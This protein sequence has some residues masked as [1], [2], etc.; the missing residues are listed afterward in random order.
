MTHASAPPA[1]WALTGDK[2]GD[3]AQVLA[4]ARALPWPRQVKRLVYNPM[5]HL[6]NLALGASCASLR[7]GACDP[8]EPP[9][10]DLVLAVGRRSVPVARWIRSR[11]AGQAR[12]VRLG[13]P[14]APYDWFDLIVTT[15]QYRL[16]KRPNVVV[17]P[18]PLTDAGAG[19]AGDSE[20]RARIDALPRP[21]VALLVGGSSGA[22]RL[23]ADGARRIGATASRLAEAH[24]GSLMVTTSRRTDHAAADALAGA[25][26]RTSWLHRWG[27]GAN[28]Y[29]AFLAAADAVIVSADSVSMMAD[30]V[31]TERPVLI[32]PLALRRGAVDR[33]AGL[34][35]QVPGYDLAVELGLLARP[36]AIAR[37][38]EDL[39]ANG[40]A[41]W[42]AEDDDLAPPASVYDAAGALAGVARRV[43]SLVAEGGSPR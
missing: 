20:F 19:Q 9:W 1:V 33:I 3:N 18:L 30:A 15:P 8:L 25:L 12:L 4:L 32:A 28:P 41:R 10:P 31:A 14:R 13:R 38:A 23:D 42:L 22:L 2:A 24:G 21:R 37:I 26:A 27:A 7:L 29:R 11:S 5:H 40:H 43:A 17:L 6:W 36:R 16:P 34:L 35:D 39:V